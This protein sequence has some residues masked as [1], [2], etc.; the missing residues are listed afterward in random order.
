MSRSDKTKKLTQNHK[1]GK[2]F[3]KP[4][5]KLNEDMENEIKDSFKFYTQQTG[6]N[7]IDRNQLRSI[8]GNFGYTSLNVKE[9]E[10]EIKNEYSNNPSKN[11]FTLEEVIELITKKWFSGGKEAEANEIFKLFDKK[12]KGVGLNEIKQVFGQY[13]DIGI[14]DTDILEFIEEADLDKDGLL[15]KEEFCSKASI[16]PPQ[17]QESYALPR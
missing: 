13:L 16:P 6:S 1:Q 17:D 5:Y 9:I 3:E 8:L 4:V 2:K 12:G 10:E 7:N 11:S 15:S 14:S